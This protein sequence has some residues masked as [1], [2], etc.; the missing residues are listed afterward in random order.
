M[1][2]FCNTWNVNKV[3]LIVDWFRVSV[4]V[5]MTC[6]VFMSMSNANSEGGVVSY[7]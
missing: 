7:V 6:P 4:K 5:R 3:M 2:L 1:M